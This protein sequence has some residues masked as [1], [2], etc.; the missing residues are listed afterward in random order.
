MFQQSLLYAADSSVRTAAVRA[1]VA[2]VVDNEEDEQLVKSLSDLVPAV[3][4]VSPW[5]LKAEAGKS[6]PDGAFASTSGMPDAP[7][8]AFWQGLKFPKRLRFRFRL[9][10]LF[11][12]Q[13]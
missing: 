10:L 13:A 8:S 11:R 6:E 3:I 5:G 9:R 12:A 1:Y 2:F 7:A 4:K